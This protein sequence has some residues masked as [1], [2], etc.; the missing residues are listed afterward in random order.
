MVNKV[1]FALTNHEM[2]DK[3][4]FIKYLCKI[5]HDKGYDIMVLIGT[6]NILNYLPYIRNYYKD[7]YSDE[8]ELNVLILKDF[9]DTEYIFDRFKY[10]INEFPDAEIVINYTHGSNKLT[11]VAMIIARMYGLKI[12]NRLKIEDTGNISRF[13]VV[14]KETATK[15]A[16]YF[17]KKLFN[18]YD[19]N[20]AKEILDE[21]YS[22]FDQVAIQ[23]TN[24][25]DIFSKWD[26]FQYE[27]YNFDELIPYFNILPYLPRSRKSMKILTDKTNKLHNAYRIADLINNSKRRIDEEKYDDAIIRLYRT[28]ELIAE[29]ELYEKYGIRNTDVHLNELREL[30][31]ENGALQNIFK[32]LDFKYPKYI[33][34][35]TTSF[36]LLQKLYDDVGTHYFFNKDKYQQLFQKRNISVLVHGNYKYNTKELIEMYDLVCSMAKVYNRNMP[37]FIDATEFPKFRI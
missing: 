36:Y 4:T 35:L 30:D 17:V 37:K 32:R 8:I 3:K 16:L 6:N 13:D 29:V 31:I 21:N 23:F 7:M 10:K 2:A 33:I 27:D 11:A 15:S 28:L 5:V 24:L 26:S 19:F 14:E 25:I 20:M 18:N 1:F 34:P 22:P 9:E 12:Q